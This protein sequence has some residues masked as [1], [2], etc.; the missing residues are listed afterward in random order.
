MNIIKFTIS[1]MC[2]ALLAGLLVTAGLTVVV[3]KAAVINPASPRAG[4]HSV[5][6]KNAD[7][8]ID[9]PVKV[10]Y[11]LQIAAAVSSWE[12]S[13]RGGLQGD[14]NQD[15][16]VNISDI[17][18]LAMHWQELVADHPELEAV[19]GSRDGVINI[20]DITVLAMNF[21]VT[22]NGFEISLG[23]AYDGP[24]VPVSTVN[25]SDYELP[26][27]GYPHYRTT[28]ETTQTTGYLRIRFLTSQTVYSYLDEFV[29]LG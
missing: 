29:P 28:V 24:Y 7:V 23:E 18:P 8:P 22:P 25:Y 1:H 4:V 16:I 12:V 21:G 15:G 20:A 9:D 27:S 6:Q 19:D 14:Y 10:I 5:P 13:W 17:S 3:C 26:L 2:A 11:D